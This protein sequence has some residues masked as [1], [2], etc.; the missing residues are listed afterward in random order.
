MFAMKMIEIRTG[1]NGLKAGETFFVSEEFAERFWQYIHVIEEPKEE[2]DGE[3]GDL[4]GEG[5]LPVA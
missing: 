1:F 3:S 2:P 5:E 4:Q